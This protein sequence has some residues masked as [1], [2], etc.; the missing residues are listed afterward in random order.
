MQK[1]QCFGGNRLFII[2]M[3]ANTLVERKRIG[4]MRDSTSP[5]LDEQAVL[6]QHFQVAPYGIFRYLQIITQFGVQYF[7]VSLQLLEYIIKPLF[8]QHNLATFCKIMKLLAILCYVFSAKKV[9]LQKTAEYGKN[10]N[11]YGRRYGRYHTAV[12]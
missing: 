8:F 7:M 4:R 11:R 9:T 2:F 12:Y 5:D 3:D 1:R 10:C 6:G